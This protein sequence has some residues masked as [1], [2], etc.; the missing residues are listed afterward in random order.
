MKT[1]EII[2]PKCGSRHIKKNGTTRQKKQRYRCQRC[3]KQFLFA[4]SYRNRAW[5]PHLRELIVPMS[6]NGSG[7]RDTSRVLRVSTNTVLKVLRLA[8]AQIKE[9]R[10]PPRIKA[11]EMDEQWSFVQNK[12]QQQWLWYGLNRRTGRIAA[13]V[14]G[15]RTDWSCR[16][17]ERKLARCQVQCFFTDHWKSYRKTLDPQRHVTGKKGTQNIERCN[18]NFR[19]HIKRLQRRTICFSKSIEMHLNLIKIYIHHRNS[20]A[21]SR[22]HHF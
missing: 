8:A 4:L 11:L 2:C 1:E 18:L 21:K 10:V 6:L 12:K 9:P 7:I 17:L 13:F 22:Q 15:R 5:M 16:Q 14:V 3:G 19:T 20:N